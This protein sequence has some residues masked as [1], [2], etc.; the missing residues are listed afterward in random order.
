MNQFV[1]RLE[2][3]R[4]I[5]FCRLYKG[6]IFLVKHNPSAHFNSFIFKLPLFYDSTSFQNEK[7]LSIGLIGN[8][9]K[10]GLQSMSARIFSEDN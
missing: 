9:L 8:K 2:I 5:S 6:K 4:M 1:D 7:D 3:T 10:I